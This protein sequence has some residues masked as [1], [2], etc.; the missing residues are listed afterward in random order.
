VST[1]RLP[2][3]LVEANKY[4]DDPDVC[5]QFVADIRWPDGPVC[6]TCG[7][8]EHSYLTTRR[9]W[10]CKACKRQFSVKVG[11]IF[12][13]SS[14]KLKNWLTAIW[15]ICNSKNGISSYELG[16]AIGV[17]QRSAWFMEHRIR[18]AM[19]I[20]T[21]DRITGEVEVDETFVGGK[22]INKHAHKRIDYKKEGKPY[23]EGKTIVIGARERNTGKVQAKVIPNRQPKS[24]QT[25][26]AD[27]VQV[28]ASKVYTDAYRAY[29]RMDRLGI[30]HS[31][32]DHSREYV[33]G[34]V[35]TNG[36]E[37]FWALLKRGL[38]G[39]YVQVNPEHLFRYVDERVFTYNLRK[40]S[41]F[42]RFKTVLGHVAGRRLT[43]NEL[44]TETWPKRARRALPSSLA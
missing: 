15:L 35:H 20:G 37:N 14:I 26:I 11:T 41:D 30:D 6:P 17:Q 19:Q 29:R 22:A 28:D 38:H 44:I 7:G 21:F 18:L 27:S 33:D 42:D 2:K 40:L 12:E 24:V 3:T 31:Y 8:T 9:L 5:V 34:R 16:R 13:D 4:F 39:T 36:I 25:F 23:T 1:T 32:V 43:Y 10:K